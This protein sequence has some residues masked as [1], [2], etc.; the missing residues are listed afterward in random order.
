MKKTFMVFVVALLAVALVACGG[1]PQEKIDLAKES[2][3]KVD[4]LATRMEGA[5]EEIKAI[6]DSTTIPISSA[7]F[8]FDEV[9]DGLNEM[10]EIYA[11]EIGEIDKKSEKDV[12]ELIA[13]LQGEVDEGEPFVE[14][15]ESLVPEL[16]QMATTYEQIE[17]ESMTMSTMLTGIDQSQVTQ[18]MEE[19]VLDLMDTLEG[20]EMNDPFEGLDEDDPASYL[21]AMQSTN[22]LLSAMLLE[23]Q[24]F[25]TWFEA[26]LAA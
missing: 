22:E 15:I 5:M 10:R 25:N 11:T 17:A 9:Y 7:D 12:D 19:K 16:E 2:Y 21:A 20:L 18:E 24:T 8:E 6:A 1:V 23:L 14:A 3:A 4:A 26:A 13:A